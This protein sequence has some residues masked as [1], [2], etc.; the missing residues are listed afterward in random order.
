M[1]KQMTLTIDGQQI[2]VPEGT[3]L[4]W[5]AK[6][7]G[8]E[9]P[10]LCYGEDLPPMS[11]CRICVVEVE[12]M[13][14]LA[15]SCS[16]PAMEGMVVHTETERVQRARRYNLELMLSDH[17]VDCIT[18]EKSGTCLL[19]KYAYEFGIKEPS[20]SGVRNEQEILDDDPFIIR[21]YNKC[22][23][24]GRCVYA[25]SE[26]QYDNAINITERGFAATI[27]TSFNRTLQ[28]TTC[29]S[30]G[31][32]VSVCPVGALIEKTRVGKGREWELE[33]EKTICPYCGCGCTL[34]MHMKEGE[35][36]KVTTPSENTTNNNNL[37]VK[38]K[39]GA[40]FIN[41]P[42]RLTTPLI[43][44]N[45]TFTEATWE[46]ALDYTASRLKQI[47]DKHGPDAIGGLSSAKCTNE[48][49]YLLQKLARNT[50]GT[51]SVDHCARL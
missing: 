10:H 36:I 19:E 11:A 51:H 21:D 32:C 49:N 17:T 1:S 18:C 41:H 45:G 26:I 46:E 27:G 50:I 16:H 44:K 9:I 22:I 39:F 15:V 25:C 34:D 5:A 30:C 37:C 13:R 2:S 28:D 38:G 35:L 29:V 12:G 20:F 8:V 3:T 14:N 40:H 48:E 43:K 31:R 7:A 33:C 24:C 6:K 47:K 23:L 42:D 4:Y